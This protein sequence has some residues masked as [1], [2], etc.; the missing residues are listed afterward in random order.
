MDKEKGKGIRT[1]D[2]SGRGGETRADVDRK[3]GGNHLSSPKGQ[4]RRGQGAVNGTP[5]PHGL[6]SSCQVWHALLRTY[7]GDAYFPW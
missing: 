7:G 1:M 4:V 2:N 3:K 6:R 5:P